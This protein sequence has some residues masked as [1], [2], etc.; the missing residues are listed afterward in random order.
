[1]TIGVYTVATLPT[2]SAVGSMAVVTDGPTSPLY[3]NVSGV[4]QSIG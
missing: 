1:M 3:M 2:G 4:W